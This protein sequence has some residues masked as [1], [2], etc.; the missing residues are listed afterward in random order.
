MREM[1]NTR[2]FISAMSRCEIASPRDHVRENTVEPHLLKI[3]V[4]IVSYNEVS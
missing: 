2:T 4:L 1:F 3:E